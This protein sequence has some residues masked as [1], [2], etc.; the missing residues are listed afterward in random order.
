MDVLEGKNV[1]LIEPFPPSQI[2]RLR[3][4]LYCYKTMIITDA[5]PHTPEE[6]LQFIAA[7]MSSPNV[8]SWGVIDK[9]NAI[10]SKHEAPLVGC[11]VF[12]RTT[13]YNGYFHVTFN[14][15]SWGKG[16]ADEA[17][18]IVLK[19]VFETEPDLLRVSAA[20]LSKNN[21]AKALCSRVG[22]NRE[23]VMRRFVLQ[24]TEPMDVI[25]YGLTRKDWEEQCLKLQ[26]QLSLQL[27]A[28]SEE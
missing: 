19:R 9:F 17:S 18:D 27:V 13:P 15:Q 25:H 21:P 2:L 26:S 11:V 8:R 23:G 5:D 7:Q 24:N 22:F 3:G 10:Q 6:I 4:W 28:S 14:R 1:D 20:I 12:E 16:M